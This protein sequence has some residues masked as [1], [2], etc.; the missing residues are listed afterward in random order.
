[1]LLR[2]QN[3]VEHTH[4]INNRKFSNMNAGLEQGWHPFLDVPVAIR[5]RST[6]LTDTN[7]YTLEGGLR[8]CSREYF[9][10]DPFR[11]T[12]SKT[13]RGGSRDFFFRDEAWLV[14]F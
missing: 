7:G 11:F 9:F 4:V 2:I 5:A 14:M 8:G 3:R 6:H 12:V 1:M 10:T 13:D